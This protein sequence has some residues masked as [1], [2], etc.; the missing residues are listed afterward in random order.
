MRGR[1]A[2]EVSKINSSKYCLF[3]QERAGTFS[4]AAIRSFRLLHAVPAENPAGLSGTLEI[5]GLAI[6]TVNA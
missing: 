4:A 3:W 6:A 1:A 5:N 2:G